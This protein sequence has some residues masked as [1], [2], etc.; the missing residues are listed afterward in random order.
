MGSAKNLYKPNSLHKACFINILLFCLAL[1]A[2]NAQSVPA[3]E[4]NIPYLV[5]FGKDAKNGYGD[6]DHQQVFF[7]IVPLTYTKAFFIRVFDPDTGGQYDENIGQFN[8]VTNYSVYGGRGNYTERTYKN[9]PLQSGTLLS[10]INFDNNAA[11]DGQ[12][13]SLGPF[14]PLQGEMVNELQGRIFK[15]VNTGITGDDGNLY[16]YFISTEA[17]RNIA[18]EGANT[19]T[20]E[21][22]FRLPSGSNEV[23]HIYP[24][25][26]KNV[27]SVKQ[28]NFDFDEDGMIQIVSASKNGEPVAVSGDGNWQSSVH[29]ITEKEHNKSLDIRFIKQSQYAI[30]NNNIGFYITNQYGE[31]LPFYTVPIGG[32]PK[33]KY[34]ISVKRIIRNR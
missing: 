28:F 30:K 15:V 9:P 17:N 26:D 19:F 3:A 16:R 23:V 24:Y 22:T 7:I 29:A 14:D 31:L 1:S 18:I 12:W 6:N 5:T 21:Y 33:Y 4:E 11:I 20:Y 27:V 32:I 10:S 13:Y 2:L 34:D 25:I 8:T